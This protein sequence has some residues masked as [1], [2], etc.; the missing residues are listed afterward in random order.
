MEQVSLT[1][2]S[3]RKRHKRYR[4]LARREVELLDAFRQL[5]DVDQERMLLVVRGIAWAN[6][7]L[8]S[9]V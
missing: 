5:S 8:S 6:G 1:A 3:L 2:S 7:P 4:R 9:K